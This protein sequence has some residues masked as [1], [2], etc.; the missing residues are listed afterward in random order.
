MLFVSLLANC[1][2]KAYRP[3]PEGYRWIDEE[4]VLDR[5]CRV[6]RYITQS[7]FNCSIGDR[8]YSYR[9]NRVAEVLIIKRYDQI[10]SDS[11]LHW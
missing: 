1:N 3:L 11:S 9:E 6:C 8:I 10:R 4:Y 5:Q 2:Q 7:E